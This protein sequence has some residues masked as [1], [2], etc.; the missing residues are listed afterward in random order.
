MIMKTSMMGT[1]GSQTSLANTRYCSKRCSEACTLRG[2]VAGGG[3]C[4]GC[5]WCLTTLERVETPQ[6]QPALAQRAPDLPEMNYRW[7][8]PSAAETAPKMLVVLQ[9]RGT[10]R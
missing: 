8:T 3:M 7:G 5:H 2:T 1:D 4:S 10:R 9:L 6:K